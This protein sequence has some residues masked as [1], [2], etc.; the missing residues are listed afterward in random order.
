[1]IARANAS[2]WTR[3]EIGDLHGVLARARCALSVSGTILLDLLHHDLPAVV[4]YR[5]DSGAEVWL[6]DHLL[7]VPWFSSVNLLAGEEIYPE[8][9]FHGD[10]PR[11]RVGDALRRCYND[12][13][14]REHCR[15]GLVRARA[16]L[17]PPG[18]CDRAAAHAIALAA[19]PS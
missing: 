5:L 6:K 13:A 8:F 7:T 12:A 2:S 15:A 3:L 16:R 10:G 4:V 17:G 11:D 9:C 14:W 18:A 1:V 19:L